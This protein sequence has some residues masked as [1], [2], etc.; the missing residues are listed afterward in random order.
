MLKA[1]TRHRAAV[2]P[3]CL[4]SRIDRRSSGGARCG[5]R[6]CPRLGLRGRVPRRTRRS[7][8]DPQLVRSRPT[9][10]RPAGPH[11]TPRATRGS[12]RGPH[13]LPAGQ[14]W[15]RCQIRFSSAPLVSVRG[16]PRSGSGSHSRRRTYIRLRQRTRPRG[17]EW[18]GR[19]SPTGCRRSSRT[20][21]GRVTGRISGFPYLAAQERRR[22]LEV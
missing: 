16:G 20:G 9:V 22:S 3:P 21:T 13:R 7:R 5:R 10:G 15:D 14:L 8:A 11:D 4:R 19:A 18:P 17:P 1:E 12:T 6:K 2:T